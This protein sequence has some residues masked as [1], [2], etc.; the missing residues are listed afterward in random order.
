MSNENSTFLMTFYA[1]CTPLFFVD[2]VNRVV[3]VSHAGWKGTSKNIGRKTVEQMCRVYG[4]KSEHI[5]VGIGPSAG[6]CCYEVGPEVIDQLLEAI[7][8][9]Q[10]FYTELET[11]KY[12]V[13]IKKANVASICSAGVLEEHI[14]VSQ[15]CTMCN[16]EFFSYR[17]DGVTGRMSGFIF[18][19]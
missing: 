7:P 9:L 18:L 4:S 8:T 2:P 1:D 16:D 6:Q 14:E 13:N 5:L 3:A 11:G 12:L 15:E 19:K 10:D 17:R